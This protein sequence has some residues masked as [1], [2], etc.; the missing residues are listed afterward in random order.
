MR[1]CCRNPKLAA[2]VYASQGEDMP[3][4]ELGSPMDIGAYPAG[5]LGMG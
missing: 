5:Q 2:A 1:D 4:L 3:V